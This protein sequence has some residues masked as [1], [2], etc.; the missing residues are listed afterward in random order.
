MKSL[1]TL[2]RI[3]VQSLQGL[4][5][6]LSGRLL[7]SHWQRRL[8]RLDPP[9]QSGQESELS[10]LLEAGSKTESDAASKSGKSLIE[11]VK[12]R[13]RPRKGAQAGLE[14]PKMGDITSYSEA[15]KP[16]LS[17]NEEEK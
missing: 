5:D 7:V 1:T 15:E 6:W 11:G 12:R 9:R 8:D 16:V 13:G 10:I 17:N 3:L 2:R 14:L 4:A